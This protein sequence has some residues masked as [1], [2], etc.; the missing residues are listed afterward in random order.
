MH[1]RIFAR[2]LLLF[3]MILL[4]ASFP[5]SSFFVRSNPNTLHVPQDYA[6]IQAAVNAASSGDTIIVSPSPS[7]TYPG[8][9]TINKSLTLMGISAKSAISNASNIGPGIIINAGGKGS[10][11]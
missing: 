9:I 11:S 1:S 8:N 6:T 7:G 5:H 4:L 10:V 3:S 2:T